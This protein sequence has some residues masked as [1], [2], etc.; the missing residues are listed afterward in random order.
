MKNRNI[1]K[2]SNFS[3]D[4]WKSFADKNPEILKNIA[5]SSGTSDNDYEKI[6]VIII[7][8]YIWI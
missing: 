1:C 8:F 3:V 5:V 2:K 7:L 4:E 6:Q